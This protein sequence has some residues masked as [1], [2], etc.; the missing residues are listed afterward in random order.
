MTR[1][2]E[3]QQRGLH[4][5]MKDEVMDRIRE[6]KDDL[7]TDRINLDRYCASILQ[8]ISTLMH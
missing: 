7:T 1:T 4:L 5:Q 8:Y 3:L 2:A 6:V